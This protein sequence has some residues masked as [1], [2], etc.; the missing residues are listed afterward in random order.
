MAILK[1]QLQEHE[2]NK[3]DNTVDYF[4]DISALLDPLG[5]DV[6]STALVADTSEL[7]LKTTTGWRPL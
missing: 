2:S 5:D 7:Y 3:Y 6:G 1:R 4:T